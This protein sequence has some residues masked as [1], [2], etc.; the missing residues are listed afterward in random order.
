MSRVLQIFSELQL[1]HW[2]IL[3][4]SA[5]V[6]FGVVGLIV[7]SIRTPKTAPASSENNVEPG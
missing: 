6:A 2:L 7:R 3:G 5:L 1:P 4:G